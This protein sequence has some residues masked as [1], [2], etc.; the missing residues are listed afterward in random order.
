MADATRPPAGA[1][2]P[3][4]T[5]A[6]ALEAGDAGALETLLEDMSP[7]DR[8]RQ[9]DRL[10]VEA[11]SRLLA[12]VP[13]ERAARALEHVPDQT[14]APALARME[15]AA[16][17]DVLARCPSDER[18]DLVRA[19]DDPAPVLS[20]LPPA[21]AREARSLADYGPDTAAGLLVTEVLAY[22]RSASVAHV[23][24]DMRSRAD[25]YRDYD[26]QYAFVTQGDGV[27]VGVLRL[28]DLLLAPEQARIE[29][30]MVASPV[31]VNARE[32]LPELEALFDKHGFYG[33]PAVD[34][35]GRLLG[36]V[37]RGSV[38]EAL[39]ERSGADYRK[40]QGIIGGEELRSMPLAIRARRRFAWLSLNIVL[41]A[42]AASVIA[43]HEDTLEA[44]IALAVFLPII[45]DMSGCSGNQAV[46]VSMREL[47][48]GVVAPR[49]AL[50]VW[51]K[52]LAV[53]LLN[54]LGLG[55]LLGLAGLIYTGNWAFALVV[56]AALFINT[57]VA[58]SVG[59]LVPLALKATGR[60]P[61]LASGPILTTVTDMCGFFL[62]LTLASAMMGWLA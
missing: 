46:A 59:G 4:R 29:D 24:D 57:L 49:D 20:A 27:L 54:G 58:L 43:L 1:N 36:V 3:Q 32:E 12:A 45:S 47:T 22:D 5:L 19:M 37:R 14:L 44:V 30:I 28:R 53:G 16:A 50:R 8:P 35:A 15:P 61:A 48:L 2:D 56:G 18:V 52:E 6:D 55:V 60:D 34:D 33:V 13:P 9:F 31:S 7:E 39:A 40:S 38:E 41:N 17:A 26:V 21:M 25:E 10:G 42:I 51:G 23:V 11:L 62:A